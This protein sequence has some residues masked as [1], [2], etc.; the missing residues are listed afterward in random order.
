MRSR[1]GAIGTLG[2]FSTEILYFRLVH[3][4]RSINAAARKIGQDPANL[5]RMIA[6]LEKHV[7]GRLFDRHPSG[8]HP[9]AIGDELYAALSGA[10]GEFSRRLSPEGGKERGVRIGFPP[11]IGYSHFSTLAVPQLLRLGLKPSFTIAPTGELIE[12]LKERKLDFVL[13]VNPLRFPGLISAPLRSEGIV[14]CSRTGEPQRTLVMN[15]DLLAAERIVQT[16]RHDSRWLARDYFIVA[17][18]TEE[19]AALMGI[20]PESLLKTFNKLKIIRRFP[21]E[22]KLTALSWPGSAGVELLRAM[23]VSRN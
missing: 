10:L 9:T 17:R 23:K 21:Q 11:A 8:L 15:P 19:N 2:I 12:E 13:A 4:Q 22:G 3:E 7:G 18:F 5:S 16:V 6:R 1:I 20:L 14:L